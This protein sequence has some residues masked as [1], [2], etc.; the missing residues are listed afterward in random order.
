[1]RRAAV[2]A[3]LVLGA[4]SAPDYTP[5]RDW[6]RVASIAVDDPG[7]VAVVSRG[8]APTASRDGVPDPSRAG[9]TAPSRAGASNVSRDGA[10]TESRDGALAMQQAL[11]TYL[12]ALARM[13]DDGVLPYLEDPFVD[14]AA[15]AAAGDAAGGAAVAT[16]G[17][18]LRLA[19]RGNWQAPELRDTIA[20]FDPAVQA[21]VAAL[22]G[23]VAPDAGATGA[24]AQAR[25]AYAAMVR[26][27][28]AGHA[29]LKDRASRITS[30]EV[31]QRINAEQDRLTRAAM[32]LP[33][34]VVALPAAP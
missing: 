32:A 23:S 22:A 10:S 28:G 16:I 18:T 13:A 11:S 7:G 14:L 6:A 29:L 15:R 3:L 19:S 2:L 33:R 24:H 17:R 21:L 4:C 31:V 1:M 9:A 27:V 26:Q 12:A 25:A 30:E 20:A 8:G 5:V 34:A